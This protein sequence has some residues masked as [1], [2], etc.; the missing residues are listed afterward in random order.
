ML[1]GKS[2]L[3]F[4]EIKNKYVKTIEIKEKSFICAGH[5][6]IQSGP[7]LRVQG[8]PPYT[9]PGL[10]GMKEVEIWFS[11]FQSS[12]WLKIVPWSF[13]QGNIPRKINWETNDFIKQ[14]QSSK[15]ILEPGF[16]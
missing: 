14:M 15:M 1:Q 6:L 5:P 13:V 16:S 11:R 9:L 8:H 12:P 2:F 7:V 10:K 3:C 4:I